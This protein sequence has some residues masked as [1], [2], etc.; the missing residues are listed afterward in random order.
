VNLADLQTFLREI[1]RYERKS[2]NY[3]IFVKLAAICLNFWKLNIGMKS[4]A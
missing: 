4:V 1:I 2:E 3:L